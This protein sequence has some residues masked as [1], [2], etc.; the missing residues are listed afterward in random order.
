VETAHLD[1]F[2]FRN[3]PPKEQWPDLRFTLPELQYP[4]WLNCG[5][6]LLD[7]HVLAGRGDRVAVIAPGLRWTYAELLDKANRIARVLAE[8]LGVVPGSR[9][10]LRSFNSPMLVAA[11]FAVMKVG[12]IA[13]AT[14]PLLRARELR[15]IIDKA[16]V[17]AALCDLAIAAELDEA[18][19]G[20]PSLKGRIAHWNRSDKVG[21]EARMEKKDGTFANCLTAA[22]DTALIAFTS[23]T[24]GGPKGTMHFHRDVMVAADLIPRYLVKATADDIFC[25]SPPLAFTFGLGG[26]VLFPF[27]IGAATLMLEK[28]PPEQLLQGIQEHRASV[29]FTAPT[30]YRAMLASL[31]KYDISS[32]RICVSAGEHLPKSTWEAWHKATGLKIIDGIGATEMLHIFIAS[33]GD[34]IRPG[35]TGTVIPG[36]EARVVDEALNPVPDG[37]VGRLAVRG[38]TGCRYLA[39]PRQTAYVKQGWNLTGDAYI[40]D[41]DGYFWYQARAD[42]MIVSAGYNISGP[43][44]EETLMEHDAVRECAVVAAPDADRGTVVKAFVVL[45]P[46]AKVEAKELQDFVKARIAPYK[47]PRQVEF[48]E[49]LPRTESGKLQRFKLR[50][51]PA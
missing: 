11:W 6:E 9:V 31:A 43:E 26:L 23:G 21:L 1:L 16:Q 44:V 32:L 3:L 38:P 15:V 50:Q 35:A 10:L 19:P 18:V 33:E 41:A 22:T 8:D 24:T 39:D 36:Y 5:V 28:A 47:Y 17:N 29:C 30:A 20:H 51:P 25:G 40:R 27:R 42:D 46:G 37:T 7:R 13:V 49:A 48:V 34:A 2:A 4:T 45:K 12:A 14:M